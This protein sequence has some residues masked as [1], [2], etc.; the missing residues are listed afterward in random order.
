MQLAKKKL[1]VAEGFDL[2]SIPGQAIV[3]YE[4]FIGDKTN[5]S[6]LG[7]VAVTSAGGKGA[8]ASR[9]GSAPYAST[10]A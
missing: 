3:C 4:H 1:R 6:I 2:C 10:I 7:D 8:R 9:P 5:K